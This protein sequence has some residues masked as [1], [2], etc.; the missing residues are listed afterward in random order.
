M[1]LA[2]FVDCGGEEC[3]I[4]GGQPFAQG[5]RARER[6]AISH[7]QGSSITSVVACVEPPGAQ[8]DGFVDRQDLESAEREPSQLLLDLGD[9]PA[10]VTDQDVESLRQVDRADPGRVGLVAKQRLDLACSWL[11]GQGGNDRL[12][13]EEGQGWF[14]RC[15]SV[16]AS[17]S[18]TSDRS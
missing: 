7:R 3:R 17:S 4:R 16:A 15:V 1:H 8:P 14:L 9:R 11:P 12:C 18:R 5:T 13:V 6:D 2:A 10:L